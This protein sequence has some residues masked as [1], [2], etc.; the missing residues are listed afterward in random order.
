M[1]RQKPKVLNVHQ[2]QMENLMEF[3]LLTGQKTQLENVSEEIFE[4]KIMYYLDVLESFGN[5]AKKAAECWNSALEKAE[6]AM[7]DVYEKMLAHIPKPTKKHYYDF[8]ETQAEADAYK[9]EVM[10]AAD[11]AFDEVLDKE[12][13]DK[14]HLYKF[15][16]IETP[17]TLQ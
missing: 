12:F 17:Q 3:F 4:A 2:K 7:D 10:A 9:K 13:Y 1:H 15:T 8:F 14:F 11:K 16:Q 5:E 6:K